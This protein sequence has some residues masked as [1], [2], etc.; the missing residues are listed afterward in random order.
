VQSGG[1]IARA[2]ES[3]GL[4]TVVVMVEEQRARLIKPPRTLYPRFPYGRPFGEPGNPDQQRVLLEDALDLVATAT[5]PG[6]VRPVPY[7]WRREDYSRIR[8]ERRRARL[9]VDARRPSTQ[10]GGS[11]AV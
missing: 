7:R 6:E 11:D 4:S 9:E 2:I 5:T 1:L 8:E 3:A 10:R